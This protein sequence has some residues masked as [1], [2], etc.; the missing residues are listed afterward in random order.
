M[1]ET[2]ELVVRITGDVSGLDSAVSH[3]QGALAGLTGAQNGST[4]ATEQGTKAIDDNA[5]AVKRGTK[6]TDDYSESVENSTKTQNENTRRTKRTAAEWQSAGKQ[7][8]SVGDGIDSVTKP[9]QY[10]GLALGAGGVAAAKFAIDFEDSFAGVKKAVDGTP[11]QLAEIRQGI[12]D[13]TT[14]GRDGRSAIPMTTTE[15]NELAAAGGQLGIQTENIL[16]F[17]ETMAQLGTATNLSGEAG[18]QA[19]AR[20]MNVTNTSQ[21]DVDR[22]GS[23]V[24]DLG[25]N[26]ATT[27]AEIVDMALDMGATG[28]TIGMSTQ[29]VL[30]YSTALS[31]MGI[32]AAAGGSALQ[33]IWMDMQNAVSSG[34]EELDAFAEISGKSAEE[35]KQSWGK[36]AD[37][38]F[39]DFLKGLNESEDQVGV[40]TQLGFNNV[41]DQRALMALAGDKGFAV[42][43]DA[44]NRANKAWD[45]NTALQNEF[46]AKAETT[47]SKMAIAKNNVVEAGRSLGEVMLPTVVDVTGG[48]AKMTQGL[49]KM[50]DAGKRAVVTAG[51]VTVGLGALSKGAA[52]AIKTVGGVV[53]GIGKI[54]EVAA[55]GGAGAKLLS[56]AKGFGMVGAAAAGAV[57]VAGA[58]KLAY[59]SWYDSTYKWSEGMS[60]SAAKV[61]EDVQGLQKLTAYKKELSDLKV[62]IN[63]DDSSQEEIEN[64]KTRIKEIAELLA[65]EYNLVINSDTAGIDEAEDAIDRAIDR[66]RSELRLD[67]ADY[68]SYLSDNADTFQNYESNRAEL[69]KSYDAASKLQIAYSDLK[70]G[71]RDLQ[72]EYKDGALTQDEFLQGS[73]DLLQSLR[74][75]SGLGSKL[76]PEVLSIQDYY[77]AL[78]AISSAGKSY[79]EAKTGA[80]EYKQRLDDLD[81]SSK[82]YTDTAK[83][84]AATMVD[85]V[86]LDAAEG[87]AENL[88]EDFKNMAYAID[89]G[90]LSAAQ[91]GIDAAMAMSGFSTMSEAMEK[92]GDSIDRIK[93]NY[94]KAASEMGMNAAEIAAGTS[95]IQNGFKN[96]ADAAAQGSQAFDAVKSQFLQMGA[97]S[98]ATAAQLTEVARAMEIIPE[99]YTIRISADGSGVDTVNEL[100]Q[101]IEH[102]DTESGISVKINAETGGIDV[103]NEVGQTIAELKDMGAVSIKVDAETG[104]INVLNEAK[105]VIAQLQ[106]GEDGTISINYEVGEVEE[107]DI[108]TEEHP[109]DYTV[110]EVEEPDVEPTEAP[111]NFFDNNLSEVT[112]E[113]GEQ[114]ATVPVDADTTQADGKIAA[115]NQKNV[116]V[117]VSADTASADASIKALSQTIDVTVRYTATGDVPKQ[118]ATGTNYFSGGLAMVND[119]RGIADPRELIIDRGRAFIPEGRDVILPLSKGAK[120]YTARQT[121]AIMSGLG[122]SRYASGKENSDAFT[123][124]RDNWMHYTKTHAVTTTQELEKWLKL[125]KQFR[126]NDKDI[127]D[128]EEQIFS[129]RQKQT[130]ELNDQSSAY[131]ELHN[132]LN[133]WADIGDDPVAAFARVKERNMAEVEA[134]RQTW[135]EFDIY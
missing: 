54:K 53:E 16:G 31:S 47:A 7:I 29:A 74:E 36:D 39:R 119:Q 96:V 42:L 103:I 66:S 87:N 128:I 10:V 14:T 123:S 92:G 99:N 45:E 107:P 129:L 115:L 113:A 71:L 77:D 49:A 75:E 40:L 104:D 76:L 83:D 48:I 116:T 21:K 78:K 60:E 122:I 63:S 18:A 13:L 72:S 67:V 97:E 117:P 38:A 65:N 131:M 106:Q 91:Y 12:I 35:F 11:E 27:E 68:K 111:I 59:D 55:A 26:F 133:D 109:I 127:E 135:E 6:A 84:F 82:E 61:Q 101:T 105:E 9:F 2:D 57:V 50:P 98:G 108:E 95:L 86:K 134:R 130:K 25:N 51:A 102:L 110:G 89:M 118:N 3:A 90:R 17:T 52:G 126:D 28:H 62:T 44:I 73:N 56:V 58:A 41:R 33:R 34:G 132:A 5:E 79:E 93:S 70:A 100:N 125:Q 121:K 85:A 69:Q 114:Q 94:S 64:A 19:L 20:F 124:A 37:G 88:T 120:V 15:L 80:E 46:N 4:A 22:L 43:T 8:K 30:G 1:A 81:A 23:T 112:A 24:V 32:D